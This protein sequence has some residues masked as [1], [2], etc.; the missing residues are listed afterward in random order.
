MGSYLVYVYVCIR[1]EGRYSGLKVFTIF[2]HL[3]M[4]GKTEN[5]KK[6][7]L[8]FFILSSAVQMSLHLTD[9]KP[10]INLGLSLSLQPSNEDY[11]ISNNG[12]NP[13]KPSIFNLKKP[14]PPK[15][16]KVTHTVYDIKDIKDD[17]L[18]PGG[19][20]IGLGK[21]VVEGVNTV[22]KAITD[23]TNTVTNALKPHSH[24]TIYRHPTKVGHYKRNSIPE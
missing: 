17:K 21:T 24:P 7:R 15:A 8:L 1:V 19:I 14:K 13:P 3:K 16:T 4:V 22:V 20:L 18:A 5:N 10:Q 23:K 12:Y 2:V 9:A 6:I 11:F